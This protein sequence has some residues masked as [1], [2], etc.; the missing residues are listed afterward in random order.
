MSCWE[1]DQRGTRSPTAAAATAAYGCNG[2]VFTEQN[3]RPFEAMAAKVR[4]MTAAAHGAGTAVRPEPTSAAS[5]PSVPEQ[6]KALADL[7]S[8]GILTDDEFSAKKAEL[9]ARLSKASGV[10]CQRAG[11]LGASGNAVCLELRAKVASITLVSDEVQQLPAAEVDVDEVWSRQTDEPD[12]RGV[13]AARWDEI[14]GWQVA[15]NVQ[16]FFRDDP[17]GVELRQRM[18]DAL[19]AVEDNE[20]WFVTGTP[21][22]EMLAR[23]AAE[24]VDSMGDRLREGMLA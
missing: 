9:L 23:A 24:V 3:A 14:G 13:E 19:R 4:E 7:H 6:I 18:A 21:S 1:A 12:V 5:E 17:L 20:T 2:V 22:G 10:N 8:A 16:E 11:G 15:V